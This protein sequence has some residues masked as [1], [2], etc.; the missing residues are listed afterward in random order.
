MNSPLSS[1][2]FGTTRWTMIQQAASY[3]LNDE[4]HSYALD[5]SEWILQY[6][7]PIYAYLRM[8]RY[9]RE[10]AE[11]ILQGFLSYVI[12]K[13]VLSVVDKEKGKFRSFLLGVL[14]NY[15]SDQNR[16]NNALKRGG[17]F[18]HVSSDEIEDLVDTTST[19]EEIFDKEWAKSILAITQEKLRSEVKEDILLGYLAWNQGEATYQE[20]AD[21]LGC[22]LSAFKS[23][24]LKMRRLFQKL[25]KE[26]VA[27]TLPCADEYSVDE[28]IRVL[29]SCW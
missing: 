4:S 15:I 26:E 9:S 17:K 23:K 5:L 14:K 28:E 24:V 25:L 22:S 21:L 16:Y 12:D 3:G 13:N 18:E 20:G 11:D 29:M 8:R 1:A 10:D 7:S 2:K 6:R 27:Q 19:P